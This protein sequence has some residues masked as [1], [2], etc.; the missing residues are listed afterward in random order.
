MGNFVDRVAE[1]G[2]VVKMIERVLGVSAND[3]SVLVATYEDFVLQV[4]ISVESPLVI[5]TLGKTLPDAIT[6]KQLSVLNSYNAK[7]LIATHIIYNLK[8]NIQCYTYKA[9]CW[10]DGQFTETEFM[11][12]LNLCSNE[13]QGCYEE[14]LAKRG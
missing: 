1:R 11:N 12:F 14:L 13:A 10:V 9:P 8:E 6:P 2:G 3:K 7:S 5:I 4:D